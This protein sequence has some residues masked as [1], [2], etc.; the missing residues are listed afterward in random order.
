MLIFAK[1][2]SHVMH[3]GIAHIIVEFFYYQLQNLIN[4]FRQIHQDIKSET[5][6]K[7]QILNHRDP[8]YYILS[9][10]KTNPKAKL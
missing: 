8:K 9:D 1:I 7:E 6:K 4:Y 10:N 5:Q 2:F 3:I